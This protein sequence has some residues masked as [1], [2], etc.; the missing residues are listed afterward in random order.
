M[1]R[2]LL[3]RSNVGSKLDVVSIGLIESTRSSRLMPLDVTRLGLRASLRMR[4]VWWAS[5][6]SEGS[7]ALFGL[8]GSQLEV[9]MRIELGTVVGVRT[10]SV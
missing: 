10:L 6:D 2:T 3:L 8:V 5:D 4:S 7:M 1:V 9:G